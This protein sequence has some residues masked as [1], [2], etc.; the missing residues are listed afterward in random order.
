MS[1][2]KHPKAGP[3]GRPRDD[4][5][6]DPGIGRSKGAWATGTDPHDL[7]GESTTEGD[8]ANET[9]REGGVD[10]GHLGRTNK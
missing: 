2:N 5:V 1:G 8:V 7:D 4:I 10:P 9:T 3:K 6:D